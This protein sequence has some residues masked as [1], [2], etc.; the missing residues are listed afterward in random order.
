M[1][2]Y[3]DLLGG[4]KHTGL[5][6]LSI[7]L[8][9]VVRPISVYSLISVMVRLASQRGSESASQRISESAREQIGKRANQQKS[10]AARERISERANR[11]KGKLGAAFSFER[12]VNGDL[13]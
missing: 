8:E 3:S 11:Q 5:T 13:G 6:L 2:N 1:T 4:G 10:E 12:E 9:S 7:G